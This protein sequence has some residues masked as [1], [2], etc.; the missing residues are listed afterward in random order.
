MTRSS[1]LPAPHRRGRFRFFWTSSQGDKIRVRQLAGLRC[2]ECGRTRPLEPAF[3][4]EHCFGPLEVTYDFATVRT[5]L[6]RDTIAAGPSTIW[7]YADLLPAMPVDGDLG[8][9]FTP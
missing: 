7:R 1:D 3:V 2:R 4:C 9:G 8:T 5:R 6:T